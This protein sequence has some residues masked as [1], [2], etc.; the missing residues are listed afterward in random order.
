M[1]GD[2]VEAV[3]E[4]VHVIPSG[5]V[6]SYGDIAEILETGGP[7]QVGA[8]MSRYAQG[9]PWWRVVRAGGLPPQGHALSAR[10]HYLR[11]RTPLRAM[12]VERKSVIRHDDAAYFVDMQA[13][14]WVPSTA[15]QA[16][17]LDIRTRWSEPQPGHSADG[18]RPAAK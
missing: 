16:L 6:L 15:E 4:V 9:S 18:D 2:F 1:H 7:R 11:E 17:L 8:V 10:P 5:S 14:R 13:A 3:L 12:R